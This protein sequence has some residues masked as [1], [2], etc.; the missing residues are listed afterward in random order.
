MKTRIQSTQDGQGFL[1]RLKAWFAMLVK[2]LRINKG[3]YLLALPGFMFY[4]LF[5]YAP[6]YGLTIAFK[7]YSQAYGIMGSPWVGLEH[8]KTFFGSIYS[9][10]I[11]RNTLLIN[12]Y[13][14]IFYFPLPI[15]LALLLNEL[16]SQAYKKV[17]Q[18][19]TYLPHFISLVVM[20]GMIV[21]FVGPTGIITQ[22]VNFLTGKNY[23]NLLHEAKFFRTI[24]I[25]SA[26]WKDIGW[27]S[28]IYL[29]AISGLDMEIYE[30]ARIDGAKKLRQLWHITLPGIAPT[31]II[32]LIM[33]IGTMMTVGS[34]KIILLY[35]PVI[36]ETA[37]VIS[38]H[39]YRIGLVENNPCYSA[40][41]GL[42]NSVI[43]C[44]LVYGANWFSRKI[45][46]TSLW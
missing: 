1:D 19:I 26:L 41:I 36:Y 13:S 15:V 24:Y 16:R 6:M 44:A 34:D 5:H 22:F 14:L 45:S 31:I 10:Q 39:V 3:L 8:F 28:I 38:S 23:V 4:I 21:N 2:D 29:A 33:Q 35:N 32:L 42:F 30:A 43:N 11:I 40:A 46:E 17:V 27:S 7:D 37:D 25:V 18:T 20:C 12:L 9:W